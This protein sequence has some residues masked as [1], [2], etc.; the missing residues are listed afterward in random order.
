MKTNMYTFHRTVNYYECDRMG[1]T[2]HSNYVR[3]MEEA[4]V[5]WLDSI[6]LG[7]ER[8]EAEGFQSPVLAINCQYKRSSTFADTL[9]ITIGVK[10]VTPVKFTVEYTMK[11][12]DKLCC[13]GTST[14]CFIA[15]GRP[16][17]LEQRLPELYEELNRMVK[18]S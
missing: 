3:Y 16:V 2:H 18:G 11:C 7:F 8:M 9:D 10:E 1:I 6:G 12:K 4:R 17:S 14:H 15:G 5:A 13:I